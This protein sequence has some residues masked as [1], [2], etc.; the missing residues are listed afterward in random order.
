MTNGCLKLEFHTFTAYRICVIVANKIRVI[1]LG[2][3]MLYVKR[4]TIEE[5]KMIESGF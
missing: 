2:I 3:E 1:S 4:C 5:I